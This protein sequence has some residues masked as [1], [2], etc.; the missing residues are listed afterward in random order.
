MRMTFEEKLFYTK[1]VKSYLKQKL[2]SFQKIIYE[3]S[4]KFKENLKGPLKHLFLFV[5]KLKL[6]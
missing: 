4:F 6:M 5:K 2:L 3:N 1:L